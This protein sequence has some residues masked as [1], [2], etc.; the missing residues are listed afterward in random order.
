MGLGLHAEH[1][2]RLPSL[3]SISIPAGV[4]DRSVRTSLPND[5]NIEVGGGLGTLNG[6]IWRVSLM[7]SNSNE[8]TVC[9]IL[10]GAVKKEGMNSHAGRG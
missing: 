4:L 3:N 10:E 1:G 7:G 6:K 9:V 2:H 5:F 8:S